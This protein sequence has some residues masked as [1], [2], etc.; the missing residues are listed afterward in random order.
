MIA[1]FRKSIN[2][3]CD[4]NHVK[5]VW[6]FE[7]GSTKIQSELTDF[8]DLIFPSRPIHWVPYKSLQ[9]A[10]KLKAVAPL[11]SAM[12]TAQFACTCE[13]KVALICI[14]N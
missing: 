14:W 2:Q 5:K 1:T 12:Q 6:K 3:K 4:K 8:H 9:D 13:N 11:S 7:R 10:E